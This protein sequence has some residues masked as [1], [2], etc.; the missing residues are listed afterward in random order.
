MAKTNIEWA[1]KSLNFY[2]WKCTK[3]SQGCKNCYMM[4]FAKR[5]GKNP[6]GTPE[7]RKSSYKEYLALKSGDVVFVNSMSDTYHENV[8]QKYIHWIHN[9]VWQRPDVTFLLLTK[10]PERAY[11]LRHHLKWSPNLWLGTSIESPSVYYRLAFLL[12]TPA[13][14]H[15][16]SAEPLLAKLDGIERYMDGQTIKKIDWLIVGAESGKHR[17]NFH[18]DWVR[19]LRN[20]ALQTNTP[21][22]YK[23]GS[24]FHPGKNRVLDDRTWDETPF[25]HVGV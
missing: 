20:I 2:N 8:P 4:T 25:N 13:A 23:Q 17:R 15:F 5:L 18:L 14:G 1:D 7:W 19:H 24:S 16:V 11:G 12:R 10:R 6:H 22:L 3:V 21:F 9:L